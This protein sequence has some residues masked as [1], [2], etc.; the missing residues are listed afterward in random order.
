VD[1]R[2]LS[3]RRWQTDS[4]AVDFLSLDE[5]L[6]SLLSAEGR[7]SP[8]KDPTD[9]DD[10]LMR[11][12]DDRTPL[13][14]DVLRRADRLSTELFCLAADRGKSFSD[15]QHEM[16]DGVASTQ[17]E[18]AADDAGRFGRASL[19]DGGGVTPIINDGIASSAPHDER[20]PC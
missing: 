12:A 6:F 19:R 9:V 16:N 2:R 11:V 15:A 1:A 4:A 18:S 3:E 17:R 20:A 8:V 10:S 14:A 7:L 13:T 5:V